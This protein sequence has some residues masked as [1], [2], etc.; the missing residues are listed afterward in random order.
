MSTLI[1]NFINGEFLAPKNGLYLE[2]L[3]PA[4]GETNA[5]IPDSQAEDVDLAVKAAEQAFIHWSQTTR[6]HRSNIMNKI[7]DILEERLEEFA[8]MESQDQG[9]PL[10]L[11]RKVDIPRAIYNFRY[12]ST[13]ILHEE[14]RVSEL[15]GVAYS[16]TT[17]N[18]V[19]V[20]ALIS[21]WNL[22]LYLLT[23]KIAPC[24]A[25]GCTAVCKPS[26]FTSVTAFELCRIFNEAGLP[27]GVV[28]MVF[29]TGSGAGSPL[30]SHPKVPLLSF[31]G[32][33]VT[34]R[35][36]YAA[37][38]L[39]N[40]KLSLEL[41]GKNANIVFNDCNMEEAVLHS[42]KAAFTN[43]GEICLCGSRIFVERSIFDEF[44]K[45]MVSLAETIEVSNPMLPHNGFKIGA[46]VSKQH[47]EKVLSYI[48]IA[49]QE[50]GTISTGGYRIETKELAK[51]FFVKP[52]IITG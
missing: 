12:F 19:G 38:A 43:Q 10:E 37:G 50:G 46:L 45:R 40:K 1:Q 9:K 4:L 30:T 6:Q 22:P 26:E 27:K 15:D 36:V 47:L 13:V 21:P 41:G 5:F 31:T 51:G 7:A 49:K 8:I 3:N 33:T 20:A 39:H 18:P 44:V 11:A 48:E 17:S 2:S 25:Y 42:I 23:W 28:N 52:T 24:I 35:M 16:Y 29:G 34:G 32:G 14:G